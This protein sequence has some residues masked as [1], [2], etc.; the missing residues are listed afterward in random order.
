MQRSAVERTKFFGDELEPHPVGVGEIEADVALDLRGHAGLF[1]AG[2]RRLPLLSIDRDGQVVEPT[3]YFL[4]GTEVESGEIEEGQGVVVPE[5]EE[6]V[7]RALVVA[8]LE[9]LGQWEAQ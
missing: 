1:Q 9:Q 8:V 6:Q 5:V 4:V 3:D 7:C 2:L